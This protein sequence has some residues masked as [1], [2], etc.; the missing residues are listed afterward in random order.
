MADM[1]LV[2]DPD[3]RDAAEVADLGAGRRVLGFQ[4]KLRIVLQLGSIVPPRLR[5]RYADELVSDELIDVEIAVRALE[6]LQRLD[7]GGDGLAV[8]RLPGHIAGLKTER[9][10]EEI[11][12][13]GL[14]AGD[15]RN[16][17]AVFLG[18]LRD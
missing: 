5:G 12:D 14:D 1:G 15:L 17:L 4:R 3:L 7:R 2:L 18:L 6:Q 10:V 16:Q 8:F 11:V 9:T 13:L